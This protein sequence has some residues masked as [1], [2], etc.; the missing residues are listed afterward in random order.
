MFPSV[1]LNEVTVVAPAPR[2]PVVERF[3]FPKEI[4]P[5]ESVIEPS[6]RVRVPI[7][8]PETILRNLPEN[9]LLTC[10]SGNEV[11]VRV[12]RFCDIES[13]CLII[14]QSV[15]VRVLPSAEILSRAISP[16]FVMLPSVTLNEVT[17]VAP[18]PRVPVVERFSFPK[19]IEPLE[20]VIDPSERVR[21]PTA[22]PEASVAFLLPL[23]D[24]L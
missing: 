24:F 15:I 18:A 1:T 6:A 7:E 5:P 11:K 13:C 8:E 21:F 19:E 22:E 16:T 10:V 12:A 14:S 17:V 2:V 23:R 9:Y 4:D 20:S 3:S